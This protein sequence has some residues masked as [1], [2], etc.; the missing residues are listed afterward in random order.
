[1]TAFNYRF[2]I[3]P[4][5]AIID[6]RLTPRALQVLCLLGR[7]TNDQGW[8]SRSQVKMARELSCGRST[9][10]DALELLFDAGWVE[11]KRNGR[12][13]TG[14][15]A[16]DQPFAAYSYRVRLDRD[17]LP[18]RIAGAADVDASAGEG[19]AQAAGGAGETAGGAAMAA[20][21][22]GTSSEGTSSEPERET[23]R[24]HEKRAKGL[25][26]FEARW[27]T[28]AADDRLKVQAAW[29]SLDDEERVAALAGIAPFLE[30]LR[31][32]KRGH[33]P[34][35]WKYLQERRWQ[36]LEAPP[37]PAQQAASDLVFVPDGSEAYAAWLVA[38]QLRGMRTIPQRQTAFHDGKRG[39]MV[40]GEFPPMGRGLPAFDKA[41]WRF[42]QQ[43]E[44]R[45]WAWRDRLVETFGEGVRFTTTERIDGQEVAGAWFPDDW[46]PLKDGTR[47]NG[48]PAQAVGPP[49]Q[50]ASEEELQD[51]K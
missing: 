26:A 40:F 16:S 4:A 42:V 48:P 46:P 24:A 2:S 47:S 22:E 23:A 36:L 10:Y 39:A 15:E 34:A 37:D 21:L 28:A 17:D 20:P 31:R 50:P 41:I 25:A 45:W 29:N 30:H 33:V 27:P 14:P 38:F 13:S 19:A 8:C 5:G 7:H 6:A 35:G 18:E 43:G 11:R 1:M 12:G 51:L 44:K 3:I 49:L 32:H 9:I